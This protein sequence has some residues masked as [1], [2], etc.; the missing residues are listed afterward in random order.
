MRTLS[1]ALSKIKKSSAYCVVEKYA[2]VFWAGMM[3]YGLLQIFRIV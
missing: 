1:N 3:L 2:W